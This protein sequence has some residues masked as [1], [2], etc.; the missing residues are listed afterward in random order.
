MN[1]LNLFLTFMKIGAFTFGG[2][3]G[4]IA[5]LENE[6]VTRR[7]LIDKDDFLNM[8]AISESTPGPIAIN[9]ATY[10]GYNF[11][12]VTGSALASTAVC[13]PSFLIIFFIS[14]FFDSFMSIK[15]VASAFR[16]IQIC[17]VYLIVSAG[18]RMFKRM[19]K[20]IVSIIMLAVC[21]VLFMLVSFFH[22]PVSS[23][24]F[25]LSAGTAG[26]IIYGLR[27]FS[28]RNKTP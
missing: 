3:Y 4:M 19:K 17:V 18:L 21:G 22:L 9:M 8:L 6:L 11:H 5:I 26:V 15:W 14:V 10:I 25:I 13:I 16:G 7:R 2:G 1:K 12:G 24:A 20:D 27:T 28:E 23:F